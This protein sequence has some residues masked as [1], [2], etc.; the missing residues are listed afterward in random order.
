MIVTEAN[1]EARKVLRDAIIEKER[2]MGDV[3]RVQA[4]LRSALSVVD[5][6]RPARVTL[7][8][9]RWPCRRRSSG[10]RRIRKLAG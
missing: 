2:L 6:S 4:V 5:E 7:P 10:E 3:R 1:A 8:P 9:L